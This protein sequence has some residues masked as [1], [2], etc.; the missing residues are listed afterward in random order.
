MGTDLGVI[1]KEFLIIAGISPKVE[2][3][4]WCLVTELLGS[5]PGISQVAPVAPSRSM[6]K[7]GDLV[8]PDSHLLGKSVSPAAS[9][10]MNSCFSDER[11]FFHVLLA[12]K[13]SS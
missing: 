7:D 2:L 9:I 6:S 12:T 4:A 11:C 13:I 3:I 8:N 1:G 10:L 5:F